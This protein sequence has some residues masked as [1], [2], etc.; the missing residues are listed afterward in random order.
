MESKNFAPSYREARATYAEMSKPIN[1][2][3]VGQDLV[4]KLQPALAEF[5]ATGRTTPAK[6]AQALRDADATARRATGFK[7]AKMESILTPEQMRTVTNV[8]K[9]LGRSANAQE[10]GMARGSPTGQN[11]IS[12]DILRQALGPF[13]LPK[14]FTESTLAETLLRPVSFAY[15]AP[16]TRV[17][18][19]LGE[20]ALMPEEARK[21]FLKELSKRGRGADKLIPYGAGLGTAGLLGL[22]Q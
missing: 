8:A 20:L 2:M 16:E 19:L 7:G 4:N 12:Q 9:D 1:Q 15:K 21:L 3:D 14:S 11:L 10:L 22:T 5:G 6:Y 13:G 18:G 17:M